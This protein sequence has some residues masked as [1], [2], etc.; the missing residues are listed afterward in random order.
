MPKPILT[1][2]PSRSSCATLRAIALAT[3]NF[4]VSN[5]EIGRKISYDNAFRQIWSHEGYL[6]KEVLHQVRE[7]QLA[8][9]DPQAKIKQ[10]HA[11]RDPTDSQ[12]AMG[13]PAHE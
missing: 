2:S 5:E 4:G 11:E 7:M 6:L 9:Q 8:Q 12:A 10:A 1:A 3:S 13:H